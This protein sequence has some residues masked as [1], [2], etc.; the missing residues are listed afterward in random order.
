MPMAITGPFPV[1]YTK[2]ASTECPNQHIVLALEAVRDQYTSNK[3]KDGWKKTSLNKAIGALKRWPKLETRADV[4]EFYA[5]TSGCGD[6]TKTKIYEILDSGGCMRVQV[7]DTP[8]ERARQLFVKIWG[9]GKRIRQC[10]WARAQCRWIVEGVW[11]CCYKEWLIF[12]AN[13]LPT[14]AVTSPT[15][16]VR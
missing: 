7:N 1:G 2:P 14:R 4:E 3:A 9:V 15:C 11:C 12:R 13:P 10:L 16:G 8:E 5:K 6:G